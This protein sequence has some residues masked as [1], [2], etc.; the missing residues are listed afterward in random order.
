MTDVSPDW[1]RDARRQFVDEVRLFLRTAVDVTLHPVRFADEWV[2]GRQRATAFAIAGP[3]GA[4]LDRTTHLYGESPSLWLDALG[5]LL[6]FVHY[7][8]PGT[9]QHAFYRL[10]GSRRRLRE[11]WAMAFYAAGG[12]GLIAYLVVN[13]TVLAVY[14]R[15]AILNLSDLPWPWKGLVVFVLAV[16]AL[17]YVV[18]AATLGSLHRGARIRAWHIL[19]ANALAIAV[20]SFLFAVF[21]PPGIYGVHFALGPHRGRDGHWHLELAA[22]L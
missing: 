18:L 9:I 7:V 5:A 6:P 17:L 12:A 20:T 4:L 13:V 16:F 22:T 15:F 2:H 1:V 3:A 21:H 14:R 19:A 10:C 8:V 11:S